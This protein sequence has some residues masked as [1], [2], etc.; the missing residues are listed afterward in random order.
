M[1]DDPQHASGPSDLGSRPPEEELC[2]QVLRQEPERILAHLATSPAPQ[3]TMPT[4][5]DQDQ[6]GSM[7][8]STNQAPELLLMALDVP[9]APQIAMPWTL[10]AERISQAHTE[11]FERRSVNRKWWAVLALAAMLLLCLLAAL[12]LDS[13]NV[14]PVDNL[15]QQ[16]PEGPKPSTSAPSPSNSGQAGASESIDHAP[17]ARADQRAFVPHPASVEPPK[18]TLLVMPR[19]PD[20]AESSPEPLATNPPTPEGPTEGLLAD[21]RDPT[22]SQDVLLRGTS[23]SPQLELNVRAVKEGSCVR[24]TAATVA[25]G[26]V[27]C[28]TAASTPPAEV[29]LSVY[30][31][32]IPTYLGRYP[33][34]AEPALVRGGGELVRWMTLEPGDYEITAC[35]VRLEG[36][37]SCVTREIVV[38]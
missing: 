26:E 38:R 1:S 13:R 6:G 12:R 36:G 33:L 19:S 18:R 23:P 28:F 20:L 25:P 27:L 2:V 15:V 4:V 17:E 24:R 3:I 8:V 5:R 16:V 32:V 7:S 21:A 34:S 35:E 10:N 14:P 9:P 29:D 11:D 37:G 22:L 31:P 30:G